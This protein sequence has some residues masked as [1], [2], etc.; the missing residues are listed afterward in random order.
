MTRVRECAAVVCLYVYVRSDAYFVLCTLVCSAVA[1]LVVAAGCRYDVG[2]RYILHDV[3][4][5]IL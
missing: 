2:A 1:A 4:C 5:C 3:E